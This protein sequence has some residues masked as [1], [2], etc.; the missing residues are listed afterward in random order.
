[1]PERVS[2]IQLITGHASDIVNSISTRRLP[3]KNRRVA[4]Y[5]RVS[6]DG[7]SVENQLGELEAV[8]D[9]EGWHIVQRFVDKG[10]SG[11]KGREGRPGFDALHKGIVRREFDLVAAWS[12]DRLGRSL[13]DLVTFLNELHSKQTNLYLHKQGIDTTTPAGKLLFQMLGVFAEFERSMIV[14]RVKAGLNRAKAQGKTLGR[15]RVGLAIESRVLDL[16][17]KGH[18]I[19]SI[20]R[21]LGIGNCTVQRIVRP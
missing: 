8:A 4:L 11:S 5:A 7:Q 1:M 20:A 19:R 9:E 6:T 18:G 14:E 2:Y 3:M 15:P 21:A 13:Q 16:R 12:V 10:I 17:Q